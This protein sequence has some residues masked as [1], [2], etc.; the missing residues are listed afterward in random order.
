MPRPMPLSPPVMKATLPSHIAHRAWAPRGSRRKIRS[1]RPQRPVGTSPAGRLPRSP[2]PRC[3]ETRDGPG[4]P[5][6]IC[7]RF[8]SCPISLF[9]PA[10]DHGSIMR[11]SAPQ[12]F[13]PVVGDGSAAN[14]A[15]CRRKAKLVAKP[16][17]PKGRHIM[18]NSPPIPA[19]FPRSW[20]ASAAERR[21]FLA[22]GSVY[23][24]GVGI[25]ASLGLSQYARAQGAPPAASSG[26]LCGPP[27][28]AARNR[29]S[30]SARR[31]TI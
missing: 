19:T 2:G 14:Q 12:S 3:P 7:P 20:T 6:S 11:S 1:G 26:P 22:E 18:K 10:P 16:T 23:G 21:R 17:Y 8:G 4:P 15:H 25:L 5:A 29:H 24:A 31:C 27:A 28:A 13:E 9:R 30:R